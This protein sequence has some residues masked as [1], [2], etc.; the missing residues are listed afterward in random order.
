MNYQFLK[1]K[2]RIYG[3]VS[4]LNHL[5]KFFDNDAS[6]LR[7]NIKYQQCKQVRYKRST[8]MLQGKIG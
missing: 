3:Y 1:I 7:Y 5:N 2:T 6:Y 4:I 8:T